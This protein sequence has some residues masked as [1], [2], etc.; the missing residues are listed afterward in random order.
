MADIEKPRL[1][2]IFLSE[3]GRCGTFVVEPL[4]RGL[5]ITIGTSLRRIMLSQLEGAAATSIQIDGVR[6]EFSTIPGV[7][8]DVTE[9]VLNLKCV[10]FKLYTDSTEIVL[11]KEGAGVITAGDISLNSDVE[12]LNPDQYICT[13]NEDAKLNMVIT[14]KKGRNWRQADRNKEAGMP[15]GVI[16]I[17]SIFSPIEK[18]NVKID[19]TLVGNAT[20]YEKLTIDIST[21]GAITPEEALKEAA[22]ILVNQFNLFVNGGEYME[23]DD[24]QKLPQ[25]SEIASDVLATPIEELE[26]NQRPLNALKRAGVNTVGELV[27]MSPDEV[28]KLHNVGAKSIEDIKGKLSKLGVKYGETT[29]N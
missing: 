16:F 1:E 3:D 17:D 26:L 2:N 14:V 6:H 7:V 4:A 18:V 19:N 9:I 22:Q 29:E 24:S 11:S 27:H 13:L 28:K 10:N 21:N 8:D 15:L 25:E 23:D 12:I 20:D 5:G